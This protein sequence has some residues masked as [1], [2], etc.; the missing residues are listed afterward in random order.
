M[1]KLKLLIQTKKTKMGGEVV[2]LDGGLLDFLV[3]L[4]QSL[5]L[6]WN[7]D[8]MCDA[9]GELRSESFLLYF[10]S[11]S[12]RSVFNSLFFLHVSTTFRVKGIVDGAR[13]CRR[14][15]EDFFVGD[16]VSGKKHCCMHNKRG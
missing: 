16:E 5:F 15:L 6:E 7:H 2:T 10:S 14:K 12:T 13:L 4:V 3:F 11:N 8:C 9:D 1:Q